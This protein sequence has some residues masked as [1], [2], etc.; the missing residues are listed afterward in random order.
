MFAIMTVVLNLCNNPTDFSDDGDAMLLDCLQ[1]VNVHLM[2]NL[3]NIVG[4]AGK[5]TD[6]SYQFGADTLG[7][8]TV[9]CR[10]MAKFIDR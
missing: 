3:I 9:H 5:V 8:L 10:L 4:Y 7:Y 2:G 6:G 1:S